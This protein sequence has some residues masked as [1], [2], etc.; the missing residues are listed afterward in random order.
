MFSIFGLGAGA[1][2]A[3][4]GGG[5]LVTTGV[6]ASAFAAGAVA[7]AVITAGATQ[8]AQNVT[9]PDETSAN[10]NNVSSPNYADE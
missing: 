3:G 2:A 5:A 4:A 7:A 8:V 9:Q 6:V 10:V 1:G